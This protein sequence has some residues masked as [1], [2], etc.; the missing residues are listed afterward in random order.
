MVIT[1]IR[2]YY[3]VVILIFVKAAQVLFTVYYSTEY[4]LHRYTVYYIHYT[5]PAST[6]IQINT[7]YDCLVNAIASDCDL[8]STVKPG[9]KSN[10]LKKQLKKQLGN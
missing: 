9:S 1:L 7:Q 2:R 10:E 5:S 3:F 6:K 8:L 4:V